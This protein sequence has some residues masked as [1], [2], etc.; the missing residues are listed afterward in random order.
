M[1]NALGMLQRF[2]VPDSSKVSTAVNEVVRRLKTHSLESDSQMV[3]NCLVQYMD[4]LRGMGYNQAWREQ[5]LTT[6]IRKYKVVMDL[7]ISGKTNR[8]RLAQETSTARRWK[9]I[10][11]KTEWFKGK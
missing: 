11:G 3:E 1:T 8:N 5:V 6:A 9:K 7:V 10:C 4:N 2:A